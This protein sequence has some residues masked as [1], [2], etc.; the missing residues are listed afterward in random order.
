MGL[1]DRFRNISKIPPRSAL[2]ADVA[3]SEMIDKGNALEAEGKLDEAL[4][5]Y[6]AAGAVAPELARADLNV[7]NILFAKGDAEN[8]LKAYAK[9]L[10]KDERYAPAHFNSGNAYLQLGKP[11]E[12][13]AAYQR[14]IR[15]NPVFGE[16]YVALGYAQDDVGLYSDAIASYRQALEFRPD[17]PEVLSNLGLVLK[18]SG[19]LAGAANSFRRAFELKPDYYEA[20]QGFVGTMRE[21]HQEAELAS[22][23][24]DI[25][26]R[27]PLSPE[28]YQI[29]GG[30]FS[31]LGKLDMAIV[32]YERALQCQDKISLSYLGM[33]SCLRAQG[34]LKA[35]VESF[36]KAIEA[37]SSLTDAYYELGNTLLEMDEGHRAVEVFRKLVKL[38]PTVSEAHS[39]LGA[40]L[41]RL[42]QLQEAAA[43]FRT[44]IVL[45][46]GFA[47]A[48]N[49]L[50]GVLNNLGQLDAS[51]ANYQRAVELDPGYAQAFTNLGITLS[52][53][54][55]TEESIAAFER[56][57]DI[58]P[59]L[60]EAEINLALAYATLGQLK[61]ALLMLRHAT[62]VAPDHLSARS[63]MLFVQNYLNDLPAN[64]LVNEA[65]C[66]GEIA[67]RKAG[68]RFEVWNNAPD[69]ARPLKIGFVSGDFRFHPVGFFLINVLKALSSSEQVELY[70]YSNHFCNDEMTRAIR[71]CCIGW[72]SLLGVS[73]ECACEWIR[74]D[75][76]D[77]LIDLSGHT[78]HSR[79]PLF[80][81]KP[82]PVQASWL[83]YFA[84][85][86][87]EEVDY[88]I[89]DPWTLP[90]S[91]EVNFT[92]K[93]V[94][95]PETRLCFTPPPEDILT[96]D[97]PA[98]SRRRITFGCFNN[99]AK[100]NDRVV[101]LWA[102]ILDAVPDSRL[103]LMAAPFKEKSAVRDGLIVAFAAHGVDASRLDMRAAVPRAQYLAAYND[104][105]IALDPFPYT[106]GTTTAE[107]LWMG[108]PVLTLMGDRFIA[109]QGVGLL[110][111]AGLGDW[112]ADSEDAYLALA[113]EHSRNL[114]ALAALRRRLREQV[115]ASPIFDARRFSHHFEAALRGMWNAWCARQGQLSCTGTNAQD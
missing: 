76:I 5:C 47:I 32:C 64:R 52:Q 30:V 38:Q 43:C 44:A 6:S 24:Q 54:G 67:R 78:L 7:G 61:R 21:L 110:M 41:Q 99:V 82:A 112:V 45:R 60:V 86:G 19:D 72:R 12:A 39:N 87:V 108:V 81:W 70:A 71:E 106:G 4:R 98:S 84:T 109:R 16:A 10:A 107:A 114:E 58:D 73:D 13:I 15:L 92:E 18:K 9:A 79:L 37:D 65:R 97:L 80:A 40:A 94:R 26:E 29:Q 113:V 34:K 31:A 100:I 42:G 91:E 101:A 50:A 36:N 83:G 85:T 77:I 35:A 14:A 103:C 2:D 74:A 28:L 56:A 27:N 66:Y 59:N 104:I 20:L 68:H 75:G 90:A 48:Y 95:L 111:N 25:V 46:P 51:I 55:R 33:G 22:V 62:Q 69:P 96:G 23:V 89:A 105:D 53:S 8:A 1:F 3:A 88:L 93:I 115:L 102:R 17:Y 11:I 63:T 49:N 57:L